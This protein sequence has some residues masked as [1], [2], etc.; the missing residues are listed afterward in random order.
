MKIQSKYLDELTIDQS[1]IIQ[2]HSG[3]PGFL[4]ETEFILLDLPGNTIFQTLQSINTSELAFIVTSP[5]DF[6]PDYEFKLN[7]QLLEKLEIK[8]KEEIVVLTI[9]TLV[10]PFKSSTINLK[11]PIIINSIRKLGKQHIL[12]DENYPTKALITS[13]N[14]AKAKGD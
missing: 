14:A 13:S 6:Y 1:K 2:F 8:K 10:S 12:N 4:E 7:S 3:I 9:V 5:Y 11:A